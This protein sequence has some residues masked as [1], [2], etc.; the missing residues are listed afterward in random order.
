MT[1]FKEVLRGAG[2]I[3]NFG[4]PH[5]E[6]TP[7][8]WVHALQAMTARGDAPNLV[9]FPTSASHKNQIVFKGPVYASSVCPH[10]LFPYS[11]EAYFAY[12]P[13]DKIVGISK[14]GRLLEWACKALIIQEDIGPLFLEIFNAS[15]DP[16]G[17]VLYL[18]GNHSC[19][20]MRG[21]KQRSSVT[22][23]TAVSR[24]FEEASNYQN[25]L[26]ILSIERSMA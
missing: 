17:S 4:N 3:Q 26:Q 6:H 14:V 19:E 16:R 21:A 12:I 2:I 1:D 23:T 10:H 25:F 8:R 13:C 11:V 7:E 18:R 9:T 5:F 22:T 15:V 24:A 20:Q